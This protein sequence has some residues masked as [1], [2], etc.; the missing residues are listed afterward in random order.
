M[1][2]ITAGLEDF[3]GVDDHSAEATARYAA[4]TDRAVSWHSGSDSDS[5]L[6]LL[7]VS[8]TAW[9]VQGYNSRTVGHEISKRSPDWRNA[10]A[11]WVEATLA[12]AARH[13]A[14]VARSLYVPIRKATKSELDAAIA[15]N[16][17]PV[18][19]I[20]HH[21]LDPSRRSDPGRV[22]NV[23]T[24]PWGRFLELLG[25]PP[26]VIPSVPSKPVVA[27]GGPRVAVSLS[28]PVLRSGASGQHVA[29]L[30]G[31]LNAK[32]GAKLVVDGSF[33]PATDRAVRNWQAFFRLGVDGIVG[34]VTWKTL[35]ELPV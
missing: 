18:G 11:A 2:H 6:E 15:R 5:S 34:A 28:L 10:P 8:F 9:H 35:L 19:F 24:F 16:G 31:L 14:P 33:G 20:G 1:V 3:D 22:G 13:L 21:E 30:Q 32:A 17:A 27:P 29:G 4:S 7:P 12:H 23:D 25:A 26:A